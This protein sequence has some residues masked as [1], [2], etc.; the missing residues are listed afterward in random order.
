MCGIAGFVVNRPMD[1]RREVLARMTAAL[2]HRGPDDEGA[3]VDD[4][5]RSA[6]A[7][8]P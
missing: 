1:N 7:G 3:Y 2:R 5:W 8:S 6:S 4:A